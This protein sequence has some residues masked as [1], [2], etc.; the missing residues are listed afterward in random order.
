MNL[1]QLEVVAAVGETGS[2]SRAAEEVLLTQS[3][4][5][6]HVAALE[7]ELGVRLFDRT[8]RGAELTE[9]GQLFQRHARQV[10]VDCAELR[11]IMARF[12]GMDG[13]ELAVGASNIPANYLIPSLLPELAARHPGVAL[14]VVA[15]D[16]RESIDRLLRGEFTLAVVGSRFPDQGVEFTPLTTDLLLLVVG[17]GHPWRGRQLIELEELAAT[18]LLARE[19]GSGS[20]DAVEQ[21]LQ[22]AGLSAAR[23]RIAARLGSNEAV[24]QA[25]MA[26]C[27]AAFLSALSV[28]RELHRGELAAVAVSGL[29]VE[30][31]FWL[32]V[33]RG[34]SLSPA[35]EAFVRLLTGRYGAV[36]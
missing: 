34:R 5:S 32:A 29:Q 21:A 4:V 11:E 13:P 12:R 16:S 28:Q 27:G 25:V 33:R 23:L 30:R 7:D 22:A 1:R 19:A 36:L 10:L 9:A 35:A 3:T 6:Q 15:G 20:G 24:K 26:G 18:P 2:F 14:N 17:G 31:R 8:G